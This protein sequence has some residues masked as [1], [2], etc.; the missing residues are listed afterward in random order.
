MFD[1][2]HVLKQTVQ[3]NAPQLNPQDWYT[4]ML[5]QKDNIINELNQQ[6]KT[7]MNFL[8]ETNNRISTFTEK[9]EMLVNEIKNLNN[10]IK[11]YKIKNKK[12]ENLLEEALKVSGEYVYVLLS[13]FKS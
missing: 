6:L 10:E 12:L 11:E 5:Y 13:Y 9:E 1:Q 3:S 2:I 7:A 8:K 4:H